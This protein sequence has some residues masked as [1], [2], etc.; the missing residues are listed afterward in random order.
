MLTR[1]TM[2][3]AA[4]SLTACVATPSPIR[5]ADGNQAEGTV[6][7]S[8]DYNLMQSPQMDWQQGL[9]KARAQCQSWGYNGAIPSGNPSQTCSNETQ[10]GDCIGWTVK[11]TFQ[12]TGPAQQ[13]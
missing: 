5:V 11:A 8:T 2:L 9:Q 10:E 3:F 6:V 1:M 12:C 7:L 13:Q 4:A